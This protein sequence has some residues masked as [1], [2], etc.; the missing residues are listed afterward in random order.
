MQQL[1]VNLAAKG[2]LGCSNCR[3]EAILI[4]KTICLN[5][6]VSEGLVLA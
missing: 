2:E 1:G 4:A 3:A 5:H 6:S